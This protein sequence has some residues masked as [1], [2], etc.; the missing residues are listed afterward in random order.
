MSK[1]KVSVVSK[2]QLLME[3]ICF[4]LM[5]FSILNEHYPLS[6]FV[7]GNQLVNQWKC[8]SPP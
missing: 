4:W 7:K 8:R 2:L 1:F 6:G 3:M 5:T